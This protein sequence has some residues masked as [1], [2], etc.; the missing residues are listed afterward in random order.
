MQYIPLQAPPTK[1]RA[2]LVCVHGNIE[3]SNYSALINFAIH[4]D[5]DA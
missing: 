1:R 4:A 2:L 5:C 3:S